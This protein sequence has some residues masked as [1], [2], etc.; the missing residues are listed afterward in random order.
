VTNPTVGA[1]REPKHSLLL[2]LTLTGLLIATPFALVH[3]PPLTDLPQHVAQIRLLTEAWHDPAGPYRIQWQTPYSLQYLLLGA[4]WWLFGPENAGR[5]GML[6]IGILWVAAVHLLSWSRGRPI[7]GAVL[8]SMLFFTHTTYWGF[9]S[10]AIGWPAF[11]LW[12][13]LTSRGSPR[14]ARWAEAPL[15]LVG[16]GI[17]YVSHALWLAA[18]L[19]WFAIVCVW[20]RASPRA[21]LVRAMGLAPVTLAAVIWYPQLQASGFTS[22]TV[23]VSTPAGRLSL[24]WLVDSMFGGLRGSQELAFAAILA[25]W[26]LLAIWS[27]RRNFT[28]RVDRELLL[29]AG[30]FFVLALVLPDK[31]TNTIQFASR[32]M[33]IATMLA[34]LA[35]PPLPYTPAKARML[36]LGVLAMLTVATTVAWQR[37]QREECAGLQESLA[38]L[39]PRPAVLGL[40]YIK[41]SEIV[42]GQPFLQMFAYS[43]VLHGGRLNFSFAEFAPS[44]VVY[45]SR[46]EIRWTRGLEWFSEWLRREDLAHFEY[47]IVNGHEHTHASFTALSGVTPMTHEGRWRLYRLGA[48]RP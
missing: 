31:H 11:V 45:R 28:T 23:W 27:N 29:A 18:A 25:L 44:L 42:R 1:S 15:Y 24:S 2:A 16:A 37:F 38:A 33:P 10:F 40:D 17:L 41:R 13:L 22:D 3:F 20:R 32:W 30:F 34:L 21:V 48:S 39:P 9:Y 4:A 8:A 35:L 26:A 5:L 14:T 7:A 6:A 19:A 43:Q 36:A 12:F 46:P 47:A